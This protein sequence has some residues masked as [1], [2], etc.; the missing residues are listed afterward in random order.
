M[1]PPRIWATFRAAEHGSAD[2]MWSLDVHN[3]LGPVS[4]VG[5]RADGPSSGFGG[6][7]QVALASQTTRFT[8]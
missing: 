3:A 4:G 7:D 2:G 5:A 6:A 8:R 1:A